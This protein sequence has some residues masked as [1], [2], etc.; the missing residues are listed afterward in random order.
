ME[1]KFH[2]LNLLLS[3]SEYDILCFV[4]IFLC[5]SDTDALLLCNSTYTLFRC[6]RVSRKGGGV[7][8]FCRA[9]LRPTRIY[10]S[11]SCEYVSI[12]S[13]LNK[14]FLLTCIYRQ[15]SCDSITHNEI[16]KLFDINNC[17]NL[18]S[19]IIGDFNLPDIDWKFP[20]KNYTNTT[21]SSFLEALT[22]NSFQQFVFSPTR[23]NNIL[24][25]IFCNT[26]SFISKLC[27]NEPFG[28]LN[29]TSD[30]CSL[31]L[32]KLSHFASKKCVLLWL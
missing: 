18:P 29:H 2:F 23:N 6:D 16:C 4:E 32:C 15:P 1:I 10:I 27:I 17:S 13:N 11:S 9:L 28:P 5:S 8:F 20:N 31:F 3:F 24:D 12:K 22:I 25:L 30:H 21:Y 7:A 19:I 14:S 26:K